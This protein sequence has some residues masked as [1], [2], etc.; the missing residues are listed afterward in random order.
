MFIVRTFPKLKLNDF[1]D[2]LIELL[3][4]LYIIH[5]RE[6]MGYTPIGCKRV[7]TNDVLNTF[8]EKLKEVNEI[9]KSED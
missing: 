6:T 3:S 1:K 5:N 7:T 2:E 9:K 8:L 4:D